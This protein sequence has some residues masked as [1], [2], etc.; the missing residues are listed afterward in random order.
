M[1]IRASRRRVMI[2]FTM[3]KSCAI[4]GEMSMEI[5]SERHTPRTSNGPPALGEAAQRQRAANAAVDEEYLN[6]KAKQVCN[7]SGTFSLKKKKK[8]SIKGFTLQDVTIK[9]R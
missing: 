9:Q 5:V 6:K 1:C 8:L 7:G 2:C 3:H 4:F